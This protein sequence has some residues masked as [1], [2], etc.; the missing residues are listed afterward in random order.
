M[1]CAAVDG[2][3]TTIIFST[4]RTNTIAQRYSMH[5]VQKIAKIHE[6]CKKLIGAKI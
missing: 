5:R 1:S 4:R 6:N 3:K 2:C